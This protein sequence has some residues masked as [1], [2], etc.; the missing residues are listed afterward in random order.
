M[1]KTIFVLAIFGLFW[2]CNGPGSQES[3]VKAKVKSAEGLPV[4][5]GAQRDEGLPVEV[6]IKD[7]ERIP[8][9]LQVQRD[10]AIPVKLEVK[11]EEAIPT[12]NLPAPLFIIK[13]PKTR[14]TRTMVAAI[15]S[16]KEKMPLLAE[17]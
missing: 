10:E 16:I 14:N 4:K 11:S 7:G 9:E 3:L 15:S 13:A 1:K 5:I 6:H 2:G 12:T 8:V 17:Q